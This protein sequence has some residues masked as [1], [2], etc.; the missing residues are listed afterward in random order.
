MR[1]YTLLLGVVAC[2]LMSRVGRAQG[3]PSYSPPPMNISQM[4]MNHMYYGNNRNPNYR[5]GEGSYQLPDGSWH[6][7]QKLVFDGQ[8]LVVKDADADKLKLDFEAWRQLE[9]QR[10]TFLVMS[11]LP[12]RAQAADKPELV[13]SLLNQHGVRVLE[14]CADYGKARYFVSRPQVPLQL[15]PSGKADFKTAMLA[16][17]RDSPILAQEVSSG[18]LGRN[19]VVQIMQEY[20]DFLKRPGAARN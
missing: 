9:V 14:L 5:K 19:D 16:I 8:K 20:V 12:G 11:N 6:K 2:L 18:K 13:H 1:K 10:D 3:F 15:L 17:V 7:S 4:N